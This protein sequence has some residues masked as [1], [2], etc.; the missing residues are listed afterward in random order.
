MWQI[1]FSFSRSW[2]PLATVVVFATYL[3]HVGTWKLSDGIETVWK[4]KPICSQFLLMLLVIHFIYFYCFNYAACFMEKLSDHA[5]LYHLSIRI[6]RNLSFKSM[7]FSVLSNY[8]NGICG[9]L[10]WVFFSNTINCTIMY[11]NETIHIK[12]TIYIN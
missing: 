3:F 12:F 11:S 5:R 6:C 4:E 9:W 1:S 7:S 2:L 10:W 8:R